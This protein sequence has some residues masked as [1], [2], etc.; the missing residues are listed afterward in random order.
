MV[1]LSKESLLKVGK[2]AAIAG[3]GA[4]L[5]YLVEAIP[6][7]DLGVWAPLVAAGL[8]VLV[9]LVRKLKKT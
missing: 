4:A 1:K 6:G 3:A 2:G 9:N 5:A 8:A 7:L